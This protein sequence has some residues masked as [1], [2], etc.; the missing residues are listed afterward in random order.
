MTLTSMMFMMPTPAATS[1]TELMTNA[2][3]RTALATEAKAATRESFE[4]ISKSFSFPGLRPRA[5]RI[6]PMAVSS[7]R[8]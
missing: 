3:A 1:A 4:K 5:I 6:A 2:P 8:L 7:V